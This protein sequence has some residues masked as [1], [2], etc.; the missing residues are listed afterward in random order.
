MIARV[1]AGQGYGVPIQA[2]RRPD[3]LALV[4]GE[5]VLTFAQFDERVRRAAD[6]LAGLGVGAG[7]RVGVMVGNCMEWFEVV[8]AAGRLGAVSVPVN[9]HFKSAEAGWILG[10]SEASVVV[11]SPDLVPSL[12]ERPE[13]ARLMVGEDYDAAL[14]KAD[15]E[16]PARPTDGDGWPVTMVYTSGTTGRPKGVV[17][18]G[19]DLRRTAAGM[20]GMIER[21]GLGPEDVHL[22]VGP[23]YHSGPA[24]WA[25]S[26]LAVGATVVIMPRWDAEECLALSERHRVTSTHMVP[27]NF[28]RILDLPA[29]VQHRYDLSSYRVIVHAAA[30]CPVPVKRKFMDLVGKEKVFEYFGA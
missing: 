17:P 15:P 30:P 11:T 28:L 18:G 16:R 7:D 19:G 5:R 25:Q 1:M 8:H 3:H 4:L 20:G 22:M 26:H 24:A 12:A 29:E 2:E 9:I 13:L 27:S 6:V 10:D 21:W 14:S 23:A